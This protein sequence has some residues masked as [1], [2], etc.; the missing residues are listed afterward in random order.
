MV[1]LLHRLALPGESHSAVLSALL[2]PSM[3]AA[4]VPACFALS[5]RNE[6]LLAPGWL[7]A[8]VNLLQTLLFISQSCW[9]PLGAVA[10]KGK[11]WGS[12]QVPFPSARGAESSGG[13]EL[14]ALFPTSAC[15]LAAPFFTWSSAQPLCVS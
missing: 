5:A 6:L 14:G 2:V 13:Q 3:V 9:I 4:A 12:R 7:F 15:S 8:N 11:V 10:H 1:L